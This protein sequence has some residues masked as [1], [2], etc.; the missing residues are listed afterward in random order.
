MINYHVFIK[1][2]NSVL[3]KILQNT[4]NICKLKFDTQGAAR[5]SAQPCP[6]PVPPTTP[7]PSPSSQ[8]WMCK[9]A[10]WLPCQ[11]CTSLPLHF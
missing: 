6:A 1:L 10:V 11:A 4:A 3:E 8:T 2:F 5:H 9:D 7:G